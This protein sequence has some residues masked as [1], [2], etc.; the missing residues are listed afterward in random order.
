MENEMEATKT[1]NNLEN[2]R[3]KLNI[4]NLHAR[5]GVSLGKICRETHF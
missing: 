1:E 3:N 2:S 4:Q 5:D